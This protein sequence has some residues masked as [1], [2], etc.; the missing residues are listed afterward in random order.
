LDAK[1]TRVSWSPDGEKIAFTAVKHG[2]T[3]LWLMEH[4][5]PLIEEAK[6]K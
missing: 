3:E 6:Q 4:F 1:A 5:L 2:D